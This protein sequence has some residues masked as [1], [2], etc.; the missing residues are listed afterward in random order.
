MEIFIRQRPKYVQTKVMIEHCP[1]CNE[2]LQGNNSIAF[3]WMCAC[4]TWESEYRTTG[5][6][7][8]RIKTP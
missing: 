3:P 1:I 7:T 6:F 2:R 4:G 5:G 8:Y